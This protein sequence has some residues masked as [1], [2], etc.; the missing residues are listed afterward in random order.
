M[1]HSKPFLNIEDQDERTVNEPEVSRQVI[2]EI[3]KMAA[4]ST[5]DRVRVSN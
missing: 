3:E 2:P 5:R 4:Q 1:C